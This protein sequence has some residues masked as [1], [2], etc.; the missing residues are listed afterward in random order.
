MWEGASPSHI[1]ISM[2]P[3]DL[4]LYPTQKAGQPRRR[5]HRQPPYLTL[6]TPGIN[7]PFNMAR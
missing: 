5:H 4:A 7:C 6:P 2:D 3:I 1:L